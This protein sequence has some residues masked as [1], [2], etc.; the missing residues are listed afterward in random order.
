MI[1]TPRLDKIVTRLAPLAR[2][3]ILVSREPLVARLLSRHMDRQLEAIK[4][5]AIVAVGAAHKL[6]YINPKWPVVYIADALFGS[7]IDYYDQYKRL[8]TRTR[9]VGNAMQCSMVDRCNMLMMTSE[10]GRASAARTYGI[11]DDRLMTAPYGA[12]LEADPGFQPPVVGGPLKLL[13]AGYAWD[14]KGGPLALDI[15]RE[16]RRRTN[17]AELHIV[18]CRP[19][20]A[21]GLEGVHVHGLLKKSDPADYRRFVQLFAESSFFLMPSRQEAF[22]LVYCETAA[23]GRPAVAISTGGVPTI[24]KD[25]ETGLLLPPASPTSAYADRILATW[26]DDAAYAALCHAARA[27]YEQRLNWGAWGD[28]LERAL[29]RI[30]AD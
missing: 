18:G 7:I 6:A 17:D 30:A 27:D 10:W 15:W 29:Q 5:D 19:P 20:E 9:R 24:V 25:G 4:P 22:G 2:A 3:G 23:F 11:A 8:N 28:S 26:S 16:L 12:N 14:R 13:F 1:D 21:S